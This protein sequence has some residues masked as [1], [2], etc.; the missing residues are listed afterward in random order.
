MRRSLRGVVLAVA[1]I[2]VAA[3]ASTTQAALRWS[4]SERIGGTGWF[5]QVQ[6]DAR[7]N[8]F[9]I[10]DRETAD[11]RSS[12]EYSWRPAGG[13]W[14]TPAV[15]AVTKHAGRWDVA[16][17]PYGRVTL[18]WADGSDRVLAAEAPK[19]LA[20]FGKPQ[21]LAATDAGSPV[22]AVDDEGNGVAAWIRLVRYGSTGNVYYAQTLFRAE[23]RAGMPWGTAEAVAEEPL[24][25]E[26]AMN[27]SGAAVLAWGFGGN[28]LRA[29][30]RPPGGQFGPPETPPVPGFFPTI[31]LSDSGHVI[32]TGGNPVPE[33]DVPFAVRDPVRGWDGP[34]G[35]GVKGWATHTLAEPSGAA[36]FV[37]DVEEEGRERSH[38][39]A[40]RLPNGT[41]LGPMPL[42][43]TDTYVCAPAMN[44]RG[45]L[46]IPMAPRER[47]PDSRIFASERLA[48][49]A[50]LPATAITKPGQ[51]SC[52]ASALNDA[53]QAVV[54]L[55]STEFG[56]L[57]AVVR[58]D[59]T[60]A[61]PPLPPAVD[62]EPP[63]AG[64][65]DE[66]GALRV[67][68]RCSSACKVGSK[69]VLYSPGEDVVRR[70]RGSSKRLKARRRGRVALRFDAA[71]AATVRDALA[72]GR[73]PWVSFSV[74]AKG[75]SPRA[76][77]VS[78]RV[79]LGRK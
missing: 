78:R 10:W 69:G 4:D 70:G 21:V 52:G 46:L 73:R 54:I 37:L 14:S 72:D 56:P 74:T 35:L 64:V 1:V 18:L 9:A 65:L 19:P 27:P 34:V 75:K 79:K 38:A 8:A 20:P 63:S 17:S 31:A 16:M 30:Y 33:I 77:T 62:I 15:L 24:Q 3:L 2:V 41:V 39:F 6:M 7:G 67:A 12:V 13:R 68:V 45:D 58:E 71:T 57:H 5:D 44:R 66:N 49:S 55:H 11:Q 61:P 76:V 22:L 25:P 59:P 32:M 50:L 48:G 51:A 36:S 53:G 60:L 40:T 23:R 28:E 42:A 29:S 43:G 26:I 47:S